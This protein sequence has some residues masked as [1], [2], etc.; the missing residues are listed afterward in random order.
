MVTR[1]SQPLELQM[2]NE[3]AIQQ[4]R[5]GFVSPDK[6]KFAVAP[7][8]AQKTSNDVVDALVGVLAQG[9]QKLAIQKMH[10][11]LEEKYLEGAA[12]AARGEAE[13]TIESNV[14]TRDWATAGFRDTT[15]KLKAAEL[16]SRLAFD[17]KKLR[18]LPPAE[19]E[20]YLTEQRNQLAPM[21]P[22]MSFEQRK[23]MLGQ[24]IM[25]E[26]AAITQ[27]AAEHASFILERKQGALTTKNQQQI[28]TMT[29][30]R[31]KSLGQPVHAASYESSVDAW[32]AG[33]VQD[34]VD[35]PA[36]TMRKRGDLVYEAAKFAL[37]AE[38]NHITAYERIRDR[39]VKMP[40]GTTRTLMSLM[41]S[42]Q[43]EK[44]ATDYHQSK[45]ALQGV[46]GQGVYQ[47]R[48][49]L[50]ARMENPFEA[51]GVPP[52]EEVAA[53]IQAE[54]SIDPKYNSSAIWEKWATAAMKYEKVGLAASAYQ[55]NDVTTLRQRGIDPDEGLQA[56]LRQ[57]QAQRM[58][59]QK[60]MENLMTLGTVQGHANALKEV[61]RRL[62]GTIGS[63]G[64]PGREIDPAAMAE[65]N[66]QLMRIQQQKEAGRED[67]LYSTLSGMSETSARKV[68]YF[69]ANTHMNPADAWQKAHDNTIKVES[70][71]PQERAA[72]AQSNVKDNLDLVRDFSAT[73]WFGAVGNFAGSVVEQA[74]G[75]RFQAGASATA[76]V[77]PA[78]SP[79]KKQK[80]VD[81]VN[82]QL[83]RAYQEELQYAGQSDPF[84]STAQRDVI[85]KSNLQRRMV[86]TE[87][88]GIFLPRG[89]TVQSVFGGTG[90]DA[91]Q[92]L[93]PS[94]VGKAIDT[95]Y[96]PPEEGGNVVWSVNA[97]G[98]VTGKV[99]D[100]AGRETKQTVV[101][102]PKDVTEKLREMDRDDAK[103]A[104]VYFGAGTT[105]IDPKAKVP[106][107]YNGRNT[108]GV[109]GDWM[110]ALRTDLVK[111]EGVR[112]TVYRDTKGNPTAGVGITGDYMKK[113]N[114][115]DGEKLTQTQ[116]N[117]SFRE[118]S[119]DAALAATRVARAYVLDEA[120]L[121]DPKVARDAFRLLGSFAYHGGTGFSKH[122][123]TAKML[124]ALYH[125]NER[126]A[127]SEL[128]N[129]PQWNNAG[130]D[131]QKYYETLV[132]D[133]ARR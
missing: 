122:P 56:T 3:P 86:P 44:L 70:M 96:Q 72:V 100:A 129:T 5:G 55:T 62:E 126:D 73:G 42:D 76:A 75:G 82:L 125:G 21:I 25:A 26:R 133:I 35:D 33:L 20:R 1:Q 54:L 10:Q 85:A 110:H 88:G 2:A 127:L 90:P 16:D 106:V 65:V 77:T 71:T 57:W 113:H 48:A 40:D 81:E 92:K 80:V 91:V 36:W 8:E 58:P 68:Q 31:E 63:L 69:L 59:P 128:K 98:T 120:A 79:F 95:I 17:M 39:T 12:A 7:I 84:L 27:H 74:T 22:G 83:R 15:A 87:N 14:F 61:G 53:H 28:T 93:T 46:R 123:S 38:N 51:G 6:A 117:E 105:Y 23:G 118:A 97:A 89:T 119:N 102:N 67:L 101:I 121:S 112:D 60:Q 99:F 78:F 108:A 32:H 114:I 64:I 45:N 107:E 132:R 50:N 49:M 4:S 130:A 52:K 34:I 116:I 41:T 109:T 104:G 103:T 43:A 29:A 37:S 24:R 94:R 13:D 19:F 111:A 11:T 47:A 115:K 30:L 9:T 66:T 131:R 124:T 18:E